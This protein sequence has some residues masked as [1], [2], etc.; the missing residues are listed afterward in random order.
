MGIIRLALALVVAL[1]HF[2][3]AKYPAF[4]LEAMFA[5]RAFFVISGFS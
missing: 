4:T 1:T 5:V 2:G 3:L